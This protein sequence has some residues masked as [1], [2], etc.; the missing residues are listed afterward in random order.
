MA[1]RI[2][3]I[4][5]YRPRI[6]LGNTVQNDELVRYIADRTNLNRSM[7]A[8]VIGQLSD[9]VIFFNASGRGVK[10]ER[11]GTYLPSIDVDGAFSIDYRMDKA[12]KTGLNASNIFT[13]TLSLRE[14]IGKTS[15]ELVAMWNKDHPDDP[16]S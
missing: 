12:I 4:N 14:N 16:V 1:N 11:L 2:A 5:A 7:V 9:A 15:D 13:G 6:E 3:A 8:L 10:F